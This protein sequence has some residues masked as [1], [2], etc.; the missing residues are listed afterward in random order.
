MAE[1]TQEAI[2]KKLATGEKLTKE[3]TDFVMSSPP[4]GKEFS[5]P[6]PKSFDDDVINIDDEP[7]PKAKKEEPK[8]EAEADKE[9]AET[10]K[11]K[12]EK[13]EDAGKTDTGKAEPAKKD[14]KKPD[15]DRGTFF[16]KIEAELEKPDGQEDLS[17]FS[18]REKGLYYS[19]KKERKARQ[20]AEEKADA[21]LFERIKSRKLA[22]EQARKA[23]EKPEEPA[24]DDEEFLTKGELKKKLKAERDAMIEE[25]RSRESSL[26]LK[27]AE[28][29]AKDIVDTRKLK[30]EDLPDYAETMQ[31]GEAII[32]GNE[33]YAEKIRE[34]Y[35]DGYNPALTAYD[36][37]RKDPRF[38]S[39]YKPKVASSPAPA[40]APA[41]ENS[42]AKET[43]EKIEANEKKPKTSG[44]HGGGGDGKVEKD[45]TLEEIA[46][47]STREFA[48]LP[49]AVRQ[50]FLM[51]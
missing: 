39:L 42:K 17:G 47:M 24:E 2:E 45:Y 50:R 31:I 13:P 41:P 34:A 26:R 11:A 22:E 37:I 14:D 30:G 1:V 27:L 44:A 35:I 33:L 38:S 5:E 6:K 4:D 40:P 21:L 10:G 7:K 19:M 36:L 9:K 32:A 18:E 29:A 3:E 15:E 25:Q 12:E 49:K 43:I 28:V 48:K 46:N 8:A 51:G 20:A 16:G 23:K